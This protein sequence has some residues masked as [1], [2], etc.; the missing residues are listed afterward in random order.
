MTRG[1][2]ITANVKDNKEYFIEY[3]HKT[4]KESI[5]ECGC[6]YMSRSKSKH[7]KTKKHL[8]L[9]EFINNKKELESLKHNI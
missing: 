2:P 1:R 3:Y 5:C 9:I 4:N 8:D 7:L 6:K